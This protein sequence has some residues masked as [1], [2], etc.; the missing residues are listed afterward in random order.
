MTFSSRFGTVRPSGHVWSPCWKR[1]R[2]N[3][4]QDKRVVGVVPLVAGLFIQVFC[5]WSL[6]RFN[7]WPN[8]GVHRPLNQHNS[9]PQA[10]L[11]YSPPTPHHKRKSTPTHSHGSGVHPQ[12][13][14][15]SPQGVLFLLGRPPRGT[16]VLSERRLPAGS[17]RS[18]AGSCLPIGL[19]TR[20]VIAW[21]DWWRRMEDHEH[22][23]I[24][25]QTQI[26]RNHSFHSYPEQHNI[27]ELRMPK[28]LPFGG[29]HTHTHTK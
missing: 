8:S 7:G 3:S 12:F 5:N 26:I 6:R 21:C 10:E 25:K 28:S 27:K 20:G 23:A 17:L 2:K 4:S 24:E 18:G 29:K 15:E 13:V 1:L 22:P 9:C 11:A 16:D 14:K 19:W